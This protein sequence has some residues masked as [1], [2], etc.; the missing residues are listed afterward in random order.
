MNDSTRSRDPHGP[1]KPPLF[2]PPRLPRRLLVW[3]LRLK[4]REDILAELDELYAERVRRD[5]AFKAGIWYRRQLP[6]FLWRWRSIKRS[7]GSRD[8]SFLCARNPRQRP[9]P[10]DRTL[11]A[12]RSSPLPS[13]PATFFQKFLD[14]VGRRRVL[15]P[16]TPASRSPGPSLRH[17]GHGV[18]RQ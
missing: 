12:G 16:P 2:Q 6:G 13:T 11:P 5:G 18:G 8:P 17:S 4:K 3:A 15:E 10:S 7:P 14:V 1:G 9:R